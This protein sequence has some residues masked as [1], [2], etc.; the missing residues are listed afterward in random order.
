MQ[1]NR[2]GYGFSMQAFAGLVGMSLETPA[3]EA[4]RLYNAT[5]ALAL[6]LDI[7]LET[8]YKDVLKLDK[9]APATFSLTVVDALGELYSRLNDSRLEAQRLATWMN[10]R[11]MANENKRAA[12]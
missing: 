1:N 4:M 5:Y 11:T 9:E 7:P 12:K 3:G 6:A 10:H 8:A 2:I